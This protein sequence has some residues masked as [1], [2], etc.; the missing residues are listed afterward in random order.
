M[1]NL[2]STALLNPSVQRD[3]YG[4]RPCIKLPQLTLLQVQQDEIDLHTPL[5]ISNERNKIE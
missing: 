3:Y 5:T 1:H 2:S 4:R